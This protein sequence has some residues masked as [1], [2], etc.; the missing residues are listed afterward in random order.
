MCW[1]MSPDTWRKLVA[2][3]GERKAE[4]TRLAANRAA[5]DAA[6]M[7]RGGDFWT[8]ERAFNVAIAEALKPKEVVGAAPPTPAK[9]PERELVD[10]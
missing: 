1:H 7:Q 6:Y 10:A 8:G 4:E 9:V 5:Y 3:Y 2:E